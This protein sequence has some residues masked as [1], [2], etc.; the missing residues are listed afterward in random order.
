[1]KSMDSFIEM[2]HFIETST[3]FNGTL[4]LF[5]MRIWGIQNGDGDGDGDDGD[6]DG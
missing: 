1:M 3:T 4:E 5:A 2:L 6:G